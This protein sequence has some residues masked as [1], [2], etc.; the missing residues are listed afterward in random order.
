LWW[1][2]SYLLL[3]Y[4]RPIHSFKN[5]NSWLIDMDL[6]FADN[7][8][9]KQSLIW[10]LYSI[11]MLVISVAIFSLILLFIIPLNIT[12]HSTG[13]TSQYFDFFLVFLP[14]MCTIALI[15][16]LI[17]ISKKYSHTQRWLL[18]ILVPL[19]LAPLI[20]LLALF[21]GGQEVINDWYVI[22]ITIF[23]IWQPPA[24]IVL[25]ASMFNNLFRKVLNVCAIIAAFSLSSIT[26]LTAIFI[27]CAIKGGC[28]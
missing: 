25:T 1:T 26:P 9:T 10:R 24:I 4:I 22:P 15:A 21:L 7:I 2:E 17:S 12:L 18:T 5:N 13:D 8:L 28:L 16:A 3:E 6:H 27:G 14:I 19:I 11:A 23:V 20:Y